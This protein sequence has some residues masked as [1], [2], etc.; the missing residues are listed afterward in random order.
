MNINLD[1]L[2]SETIHSIFHDWR[3]RACFDAF[4]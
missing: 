4:W 3:L 2:D 1:V